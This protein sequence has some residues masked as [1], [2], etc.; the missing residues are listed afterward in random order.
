VQEWQQVGE[1][2]LVDEQG[3]TPIPR[4]RGQAPELEHRELVTVPHERDLGEA[5]RTEECRDVGQRLG[6]CSEL[7][8]VVRPR[9]RDHERP[10]RIQAPDD[11]QGVDGRTDQ[12]DADLRGELAVVHQ[13]SQGARAGGT[14]S[15]RVELAGPG[16]Q[17]RP[18]GRVG[19]SL[20]DLDHRPVRK[21]AV[22]LDEEPVLRARAGEA[23]RA[24]QED[25]HPD[26]SP[27]APPAS[28]R[29]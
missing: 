12:E 7:R 14:G 23:A 1:D 2:A 8:C 29:T 27:P 13:R 28:R 3:L 4:S 5:P 25:P 15:G 16:S 20:G 17:G 9:H 11:T 21:T 24:R 6:A 19:L 18:G 26:D 10:Q 22:D